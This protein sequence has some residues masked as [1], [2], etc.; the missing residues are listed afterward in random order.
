MFAMPVAIKC[1]MPECGS[2]MSDCCFQNHGH[3]GWYWWLRHTD[4]NQWPVIN[5]RWI[6]WVVA[7]HIS[8][9]VASTVYSTN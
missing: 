9:C 6:E 2:A 1:M 7:Q 5:H 8:S 3:C 4:W